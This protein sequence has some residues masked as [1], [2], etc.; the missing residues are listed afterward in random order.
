M[1]ERRI[2][3]EAH[4]ECGIDRELVGRQ[5]PEP[6]ADDRAGGERY[7]H[8][9]CIHT[10]ARILGSRPSLGEHAL[11]RLDDDRGYPD[12][13]TNC[14]D[15]RRIFE[16]RQQNARRPVASQCQLLIAIAERTAFV[17][18]LLEHIGIDVRDLVPAL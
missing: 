6:R 12:N 5:I 4:G 8:A 10:A 17:V 9:L 14:I 16:V 11:C 2:E 13:G 7:L 3:A 1:P 15:G 18:D